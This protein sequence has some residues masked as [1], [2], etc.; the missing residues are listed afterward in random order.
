MAMPRLQ[1]ASEGGY[2]PCQMAGW[3]GHM[4]N[5]GQYVSHQKASEQKTFKFDVWASQEN[6]IR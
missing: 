3:A 4:A 5:V 2:A 6:E 1:K